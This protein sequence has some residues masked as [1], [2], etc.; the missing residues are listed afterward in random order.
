MNWSEEG[1]VESSAEHEIYARQF[2]ED[3][4]QAVIKK[5]DA[6]LQY[7]P[8]THAHIVEVLFHASMCL[9]RSIISQIKK[10]KCSVNWL[11]LE[12]YFGGVTQ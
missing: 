9:S 4:K 8:L 5:V 11:T 10:A 1:I 3:F 6:A 7:E 12:K 2:G